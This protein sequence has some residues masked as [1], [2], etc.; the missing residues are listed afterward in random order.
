MLPPYTMGILDSTPATKG[1][2]AAARFKIIRRH[3]YAFARHMTMKKL[4]NFLRAERDRLRRRTVVSSLPYIL[5]IEPSNICNLKCAYCYDNRRPPL[6]GERPYGRMSFAQFKGL[7]DDIG[8][9]LFK[10]NLYG[11]GEP[12]LFPETLQMIEYAAGKNIGVGVSS[13]MNFR[14]ENLPRRIVSSGLEVLIFSCHGVSREAYGKFMQKGDPD[15]ALSNLA[16]VIEERRRAG[17]K[18]PLIDWQYCVTGFNEHEMDAAAAK[19]REIGVDQ[20]R[21]IKPFFPSDAPDEWFSTMF[22]KHTFAHE[23]EAPPGCSWPYRS[24]YVNY[25]GGLLP[26][27][28]D[29][30]KVANDFG[31][32]FDQGL[33]AVWN[34]DKYQAARALIAD[35]ANADPKTRVMC[36]RCPVVADRRKGRGA[37]QGS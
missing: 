4:G 35:P 12:W 27:C 5:K 3:L 1:V 2:N 21:F 18:T 23:D 29:F 24:A 11:F 16:L 6:D 13:N 25:D 19:A 7:I 34:N 32:V 8:D 17:K 33:R 30:R 31:N 14:D 26:C 28:R 22:P 37:S 20:I 15:L 9:V 36:L 10:I